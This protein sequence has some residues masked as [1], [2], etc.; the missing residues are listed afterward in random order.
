MYAFSLISWSASRFNSPMVSLAQSSL[1]QPGLRTVESA[2][3]YEIDQCRRDCECSHMA[4]PCRTNATTFAAFGSHHCA[5]ASIIVRRFSRASPRRYAAS[6]L[7][8]IVCA[9]A[10]SRSSDEN[11]LTS[12]AQSENVDRKPCEVVVLRLPMRSNSMSIAILDSGLP[13][14]W[15]GKTNSET[16]PLREFADDGEGTLGQRHAMLAPRLH[17]RRRDCPEPRIEIEFSPF[18]IQDFACP[19]HSQY[20]QFEG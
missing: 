6:A 8:P 12:E 2:A 13:G 15:P 9:R 3:A 18:R 7:L 14:F 16:S 17:A 10:L 1:A 20:G 4:S 11:G 5:Q 19:R